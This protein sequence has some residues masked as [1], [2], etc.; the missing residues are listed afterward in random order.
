MVSHFPSRLIGQGAEAWKFEKDTAMIAGSL[1]SGQTSDEREAYRD[2]R[3]SSLSGLEIVLDPLMN[4]V[5]IYWIRHEK[6]GPGVL[7]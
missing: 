4:N 1:D 3:C 2:R 7:G 5:T 6:V